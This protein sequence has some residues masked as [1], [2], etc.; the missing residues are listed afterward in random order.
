[1]TKA[2]SMMNVCVEM[3]FYTKSEAPLGGSTH[4]IH[5][6]IFMTPTHTI[7]RRSKVRVYIFTVKDYNV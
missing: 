7:Q 2:D 3:L 4:N 6:Q 1:M 5:C